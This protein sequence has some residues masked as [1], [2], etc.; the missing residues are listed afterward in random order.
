MF[1]WNCMHE[2]NLSCFGLMC[3]QWEVPDNS[4]VL[5]SFTD[6]THCVIRSALCTLSELIPILKSLVLRIAQRYLSHGYQFK[7]RWFGFPKCCSQN[8]FKSGWFL[9]A[10][11]SCFLA[12]FI[13]RNH[14]IICFEELMCTIF[15]LFC[16]L[17]LY[18]WVCV[19]IWL[20]ELPSG[21]GVGMGKN[22]VSIIFSCQL[23]QSGAGVSLWCFKTPLKSSS[24]GI[25]NSGSVLVAWVSGWIL[26]S[27]CDTFA[28]V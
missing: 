1:W 28:R 19:F 13:P 23:S 17:N 9:C 22:L 20:T 5:C 21:L 4:M 10:F 26:N 7:P 12:F 15:L 16:R 24:L 25:V 8:F 11:Q 14:F 6:D 2:V 27:K 3:L 18:D